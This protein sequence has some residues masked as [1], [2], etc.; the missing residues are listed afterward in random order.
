MFIHL[1]YLACLSLACLQVHCLPLHFLPVL[2]VYSHLLSFL[3]PATS[4]IGSN[5]T[6][7][8]LTLGLVFTLSTQGV[9]ATFI[10]FAPASLSIR[11]LIWGQTAGGLL[12]CCTFWHLQYCLSNLKACLWPFP[13]CITS[14]SLN[15]LK[16]SVSVKEASKVQL[17]PCNF[18][19]FVQ[20]Y[21]IRSFSS[22]LPTYNTQ[23][24]TV[25]LARG[26]VE[27]I[28]YAYCQIGTLFWRY[29]TLLYL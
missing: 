27:L 22:V 28:W 4:S 16:K 18:P 26:S 6:Q 20:I 15:N 10:I 24:T 29:Y 11:R 5:T 8:P 23:H 25:H 7:S 1:V 19:P 3:S 17:Q 13:Q 21:W 14:A 9:S 2:T 12:C